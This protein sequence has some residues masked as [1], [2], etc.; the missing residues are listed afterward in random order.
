MFKGK[1]IYPQWL[2][3]STTCG[4]HNLTLR[5]RLLSWPDSSLSP[6]WLLCSPRRATDLMLPI[7]HR[8]P[9]NTLNP[10]TTPQFRFHLHLTK[11]GPDISSSWLTS[12]PHVCGIWLVTVSASCQRGPLETS[13]GGRSRPGGG[14]QSKQ[15][16]ST[17]LKWPKGEENYMHVVWKHLQ[18]HIDLPS[19][20]NALWCV[21][22][23]CHQF[24]CLF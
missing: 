19:S 8:G 15:S 3:L 2:R 13:H 22:S 7:F 6:R 4:V 18:T 24:L 10:Y 17:P 14:G 9:S 5:S 23:S 12:L 16:T 11:E 1:L 21:K 20:Q